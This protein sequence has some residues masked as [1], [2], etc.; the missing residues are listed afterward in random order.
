MR[1][2]GASPV[3]PIG[4]GCGGYWGLESFPA[5]DAERLIRSALDLGI[6]FFDTGPNYSRGNAEVRLGN[7][8]R[9]VREEMFIGTKV[10]SVWRGG[11]N[12]RDLSANGMRESAERSARVLGV[13]QLDLVQLHCRLAVEVEP[14]LEV[15]ADLRKRG[16][17]RYIGVSGN[18]DAVAAAIAT[19]GF[20]CVMVTYN[21]VDQR[22]KQIIET[23]GS[24]HVAVAVKSPLAHVAYLQRIYLPTN[25]RRAWYL[26]RILKTYRKELVTGRRLRFINTVGSWRGPEVAL[27]FVL[28]EESV[29][30]AVVGTTDVSH[31][32]SLVSAAAG[33]PLCDELIDRIRQAVR[34]EPPPR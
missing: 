6:S 33:P 21:V 23:A 34:V 14:S 7:I 29:T 11:R 5:T 27:K 31:L 16:L 12:Q 15:L 18:V 20:D 1:Q 25:R 28:H 9:R 32:E 13:D 8:R 2:L 26:L 10:G 3:S 24:A 22:A 17:C 30:T 4:F 19:G